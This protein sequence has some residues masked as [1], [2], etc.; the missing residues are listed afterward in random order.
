MTRMR[1]DSFALVVCDGPPGST[2]GGRFGLVPIMRERLEPGCVILLD[3]ASREQ[4]LAIA[5]RWEA[6]IGASFEILD[7]TKPYI[8]MTVMGTA[9]TA[10]SPRYL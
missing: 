8:K 4:E 2:K 6:E 7:C 9:V 10:D 5:R 3:D 1:A